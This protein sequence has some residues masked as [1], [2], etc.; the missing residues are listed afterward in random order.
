MDH[1]LLSSLF[2]S[3]LL[4]LSL[5][6]QGDIS[7]GLLAAMS[8]PRIA[9]VTG[10]V[11]SLLLFLYQAAPNYDCRTVESGVLSALP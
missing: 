5:Y 9:V 1:N 10:A 3:L 4:P 2:L 11:S 7:S 8:S 6:S